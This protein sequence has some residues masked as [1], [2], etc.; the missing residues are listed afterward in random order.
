MKILKVDN[1]FMMSVVAAAVSSAV[2][3]MSFLLL[4]PTVG[5][6]AT[7]TT[8]IHQTITAELSVAVASSSLTMDGAIAGITGGST[9]SATDVLVITNNSAGYS[10]TIQ[11]SS[12]TAMY[13]N[14]GGGEIPNYVATSIPDY[15]FDSTQVYGQFGYSAYSTTDA[16]DID[17]TFL[18]NGSDTCNTGATAAANTCWL[19]PSSTAAE[20]IVNRTT[21]TPAEGATTTVQF[22][23]D[24]P[25]NPVPAVNTG[26][27]TAT[28]TLTAVIN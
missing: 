18:S 5:Q 20:T 7:D 2:L 23:V 25:L 14:G 1:A 19:S 22:R 27:Y 17:P 4:E 16:G 6:A 10:M 9:D 3:M 13:R 8:E 26:V 11:F 15:T 28:A 12:S 21:A 24:I